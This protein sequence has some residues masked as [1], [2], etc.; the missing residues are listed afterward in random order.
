MPRKAPRPHLTGRDGSQALR[1]AG[2]GLR[3]ELMRSARNL[4]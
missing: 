2:S 3:T 1:V 4:T